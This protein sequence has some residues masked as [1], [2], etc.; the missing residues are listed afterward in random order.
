MRGKEKSFARC[1]SK[2]EDVGS[3]GKKSERADKR[4]GEK[5]KRTS[6]SAR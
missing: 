5:E 6:G 2:K 1:L 3:C 4:D